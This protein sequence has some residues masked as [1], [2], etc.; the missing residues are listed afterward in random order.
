MCSICYVVNK[1]KQREKN[2]L[3]LENVY[4][5]ILL[6][7]YN[8]YI[9]NKLLLNEFITE[10]I[11]MKKLNFNRRKFL[12][13]TATTA[14]GIGLL[15]AFP[16]DAFAS[17]KPL[18]D[19]AKDSEV[20][21]KQNPDDP[22]IKF[23]V[24]G[25]NHGHIYS[26]VDAVMRGG[27]QLISL[28]AKEPDLVA[29]FTK[30]YPQVKAAASEK[31]ILED[32]SIQLILSAA[33]PVDRAG[34]GI[35]SMQHGKDYMCDKPGITSLEQLAEVR[36]VQKQTGRIYSIM[37]SERF[38]NKATVKAG[39]L[40][41]AGAIGKVIQTIGLGPHRMNAGT[42]PAWFFD[43]KYFGGIITDI[44]HACKQV[45]K[46]FSQCHAAFLEANYRIDMLANS[47]YPYFLQQRI[48]SDEGHL[49]NAQALDLFINYKSPDLRL[50]ILS[51]L[52]KNN[53]NP[54][55]VETLFNQQAGD[56]QIVVASRYEATPVFCISGDNVSVNSKS[57]RRAADKRQ[58]SL[59]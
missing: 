26:Q 44:G 38:E 12:K 54:E 30:K 36:R 23:S 28:Y 9:F 46:Y 5:N 58:L 43:R 40:V 6:S 33:I 16:K 39:D 56:T 47:S 17:A 45:M 7:G 11:N 51:H 14:T 15:S 21:Y 27:G 37:Y 2:K 13:Y 8:T 52:S 41:K 22:R 31:E 55:L 32:K 53:N 25:I 3:Y 35:R 49:S 1:A 29:A 20:K 10:N 34:I 24:I 48:S 50:L 42:R 57:K 59:F 18:A 4:V 19:E